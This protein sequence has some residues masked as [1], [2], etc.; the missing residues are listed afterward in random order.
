[1]VLGKIAQASGI[2]KDADKRMN[3]ARIEWYTYIHS[4][5]RRTRDD[6]E[7][8]SVLTWLIYSFI[9]ILEFLHGPLKRMLDS[10]LSMHML[11]CTRKL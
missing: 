10:Q 4:Y 9:Y 2:T 7:W 3:D 11:T 6:G 5:N 8:R 1:M